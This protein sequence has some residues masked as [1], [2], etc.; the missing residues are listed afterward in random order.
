MEKFVPRAKM[1]PKARRALDA[2]K[3]V[4]W[5]ICPTIKL[6]ESKRAY[7]RRKIAACLRAAY[8]DE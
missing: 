4:F 6:I 5:T 2:K 3:R 7:N 1:N 8:R